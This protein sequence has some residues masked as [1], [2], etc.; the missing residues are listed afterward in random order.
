MSAAAIC[1]T[2]TRALLDMAANIGWYRMNLEGAPFRVLRS[3]FSITAF[4]CVAASPATDPTGCIAQVPLA[5]T[6]HP[7]SNG[8]DIGSWGWE[9][10]TL[11]SPAGCWAGTERAGLSPRS[12]VFAAALSHGHT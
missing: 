10:R 6:T 9:Y 1:P 3:A 5:A 4:A 12:T 2:D 11:M 8:D 7:I